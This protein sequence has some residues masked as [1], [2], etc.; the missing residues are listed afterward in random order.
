MRNKHFLIFFFLL[1]PILFLPFGVKAIMNSIVIDFVDLS[2]PN[3]PP[4]YE[5]GEV[6]TIGVYGTVDQSGPSDA[7]AGAEID[8]GDGDN[9][10]NPGDFTD[11]NDKFVNGFTH[12]YG[13]PGTFILNVRACAN[14][15]SGIGIWDA[16]PWNVCVS[17]SVSI[18]I[19]GPPICDGI[20][21][22]GYNVHQDPDC[23]CLDGD[24]CCGIGCDDTNDNDCTG[25]SNTSVNRYRNP[26]I[27]DD[28]IT[29]I[30]AAI[31]SIFSQSIV[32]AV[33]MILIG[34]YVIATSGGNITRVQLGKRIII[35]TI[36]GYAVMLLARGIIMFIIRFPSS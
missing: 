21:S 1:F 25:T 3:N 23:G 24:G 19:I 22:A 29:F 6:I 15:M 9:E 34:A 11:R 20:C 8:F 12:S 35:W 26:L 13:V 28:I 5:T 16:S 17:K 7:W 30:W 2:V 32:L 4:S 18:T 36:I 14:D 31:I 10:R 33:L 27:W